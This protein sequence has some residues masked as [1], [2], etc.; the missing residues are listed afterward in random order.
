M[1]F[2]GTSVPF[3]REKKA[4]TGGEG[5]GDLGGKMDRVWGRGKRGT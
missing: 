2:Q 3:E 1:I 5:G 4:I